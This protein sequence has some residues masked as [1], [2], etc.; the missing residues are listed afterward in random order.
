[1]RGPG[2]GAQV[3]QCL[4]ECAFNTLGPLG[5]FLLLTPSLVFGLG[6]EVIFRCLLFT[7]LFEMRA[8]EMRAI[9]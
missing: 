7:R 8:F 2:G 5:A 6:N 4:S 1:M 3:P 9:F